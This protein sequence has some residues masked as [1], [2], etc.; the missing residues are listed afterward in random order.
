M[1]RIRTLASLS[2]VAL[3]GCHLQATAGPNWVGHEDSELAGSLELG[4]HAQRKASA[5]VGARIGTLVDFDEGV[6]LKNGMLHGGFD[7]PI[8]PGWFMLEP[9]ADFGAG[10]PVAQVFDGSGAYAGASLNMR[11]RP[12][13]GGDREPGFNIA[14]P[15]GELVVTSRSGVWMPPEHSN[16]TAPYFDFSI[17]VGIRFG[18]GSDLVS[19]AQ[20][21]VSDE[22]TSQKEQE[23]SPP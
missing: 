7:W 20:G 10:Q 18:L 4:T 17:E 2:L 3:P 22:G 14:F 12:T 16:T 6:T 21:R 23:E 15:I 5:V 8:V 9:G 1:T 19:P 11:F 13:P